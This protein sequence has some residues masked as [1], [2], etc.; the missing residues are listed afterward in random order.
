MAPGLLDVKIVAAAEVIIIVTLKLP[1]L[2]Y[3]F[4]CEIG[5][6]VFMHTGGEPGRFT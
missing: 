2:Q 1:E 4:S 3:Y 6:I 5:L